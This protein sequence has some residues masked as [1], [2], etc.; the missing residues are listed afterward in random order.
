MPWRRKWQ[1][2]PIFLPGE[3]HGH[4]NLAGYSPRGQKE[5]KTTEPTCTESCGIFQRENARKCNL[6]LISF[7]D[8]FLWYQKFSRRQ[9]IDWSR[10]LC[11]IVIIER[12]TYCLPPPKFLIEM[13]TFYVNFLHIHIQFALWQRPRWHARSVMVRTSWSSQ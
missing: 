5:S 6:F 8:I 4:R 9:F 2:M 11:I 3:S 12:N 1:P 10:R 13:K 7:C